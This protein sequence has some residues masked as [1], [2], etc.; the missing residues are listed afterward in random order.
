MR[1]HLGKTTIIVRRYAR[2][3]LF[4]AISIMVIALGGTPAV[5]QDSAQGEVI[6]REYAIKAGFLYHFLSY[7]AWPAESLPMEGEP[8]II[9]VYQ[10]NP[11]GT[12]L[13]EIARTKKLDGHPIEIRLIRSPE[14]VRQ[15]HVVF[16][17]ASISLPQQNAIFRAEEGAH[18]LVVGE[19]G[20]FVER[21]G[22]AQFYI[23]DNKVRFAFSSDAARG[24]E[25][26]V[27][28]KLLALAKIIPK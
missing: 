6:N 14:G 10:S 8:Y 21:G 27:S 11:F 9:G 28:S 24:E 18:V 7:I 13:D 23:E 2:D 12:A 19:S 20:E 5:S 17:P 22:D 16:V 4:V 3:I 15:C 25:H 1:L 26:K